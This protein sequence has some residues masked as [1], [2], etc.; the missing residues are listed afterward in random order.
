MNERALFTRIRWR[1][2]GWTMLIVGLILALIGSTVYITLS[3]SLINQVDRN[4]AS[5]SEPAQAFPLLFGRPGG[6]PD[7]GSPH[8][9]YSGGL[10]YLARQADGQVIA[11]PQQV[12]VA[13]VVW[14]ATSDQ[15]PTFATITLNDEVTRVTLRRTPDGGSLVVGQ[16]LAPEQ[17]ALHWLLLFL[18][19]GGALGLLLT[20]AGAW[21]LAGRALLPIQQAFRRQQEFI[22]DASHELR[23]PLTVLRSATDVLDRQRAEPL[24]KNADLLDDVR[25]EIGRMSRLVHDLLTVARSDRGELDLMTAPL[26]LAQLTADIVRRTMPL[27]DARGSQLVFDAPGSLA[28]VD[29]DPDRIQQAL[30]ILLDNAVKFTPAGGRIEVSVHTEGNSAVVD[31]ADTGPGIAPQDLPR[32]FDRFYRSDK[33]RSSTGGTGLGLTI[34]RM[35]VEAD[36]HRGELTLSSKPGM[37]TVARI[38]LPLMSQPASLGHRLG[39]FAASLAHTPPRL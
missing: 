10:F 25:S 37:G 36:A 13:G 23:T 12:Q 17:T 27:A 9:G 15:A 7:R 19:G 39:D 21:F 2:V 16:S 24:A 29:V 11:N 30:L 1:L 22:A 8:E 3:R 35:L 38:K 20:L 18:I 5:R 31:V 4:L 32:V 26:D 6:L 33:A 34:A 28:M 14:P